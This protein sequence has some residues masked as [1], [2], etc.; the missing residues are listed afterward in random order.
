MKLR[1]GYGRLILDAGFVLVFVYFLIEALTYNRLARMVP[2]VVAIPILILCLV[3]FFTDLKKYRDKSSDEKHTTQTGKKA[4]VTTRKEIETFLW[5][6][7]FA[8]GIWLVGY[9]ITIPVF[10]LL[11]TRFVGKDSWKIAIGLAVG[12]EAF[13]YGIFVTVVKIYL[14]PGLLFL[15]IAKL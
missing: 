9:H 15:A 11:F 8:I 10:T 2:V 5:V 12:A 4:N 3:L 6:I 14:Y 7:G 1:R 13:V